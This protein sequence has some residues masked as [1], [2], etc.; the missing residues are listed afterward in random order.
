MAGFRIKRVDQVVGRHDQ[1][2]LI[3]LRPI[4]HAATT[5]TRGLCQP[6]GP[7]LHASGGIDGNG[8]PVWRESEQ[9]AVN[10]NRLGLHGDR[11]N[12]QPPNL[13][14]PVNIMAPD[15]GQRGIARAALIAAIGRPVDI[16]SRGLAGQRDCANCSQNQKPCFRHHRLRPISRSGHCFLYRHHGYSSHS[17]NFYEIDCF[18]QLPVYLLTSPPRLGSLCACCSLT[19]MLLMICSMD[20]LP[21]RSGNAL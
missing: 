1:P 5:S 4:S 3:A 8:L 20:L 16:L 12:I 14:Q 2:L 21:N 18:L 17:S 6:I 7:F 15:L 11:C 13:L 9:S 19:W 10:D